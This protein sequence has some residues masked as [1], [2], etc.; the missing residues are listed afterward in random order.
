MCVTL[1]NCSTN[2]VVVR[3]LK[4]IIPIASMLLDGKF[5]H[6]RC[7]SHILNLVVQEGVDIAKDVTSKIRDSVRYV[8]S[9]TARQQKFDSGCSN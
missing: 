2:D 4:E 9:S 5:F 3:Q 1:D 6:V 7:T 8:K